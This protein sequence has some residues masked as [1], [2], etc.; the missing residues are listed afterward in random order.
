[1]E[2][3]ELVAFWISEYLERLL[4]GLADVRSCRTKREQVSSVT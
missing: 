1:M 3:A 2:S 4:A